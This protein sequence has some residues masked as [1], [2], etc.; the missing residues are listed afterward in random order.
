MQEHFSLNTKLEFGRRWMNVDRPQCPRNH[1]IRSIIM[2]INLKCYSIL[3]KVIPIYLKWSFVVCIRKSSAANSFTTKMLV[4]AIHGV[5][6]DHSLTK[7]LEIAELTEEQKK[8]LIQ[9]GKG[10]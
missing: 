5:D 9:A 4:F 6:T 8:E 1:H 7:R 10:L 3:I 2:N